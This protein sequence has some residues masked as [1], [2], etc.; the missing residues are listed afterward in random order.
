MMPSF[1]R[2]RRF[3]LVFAASFSTLAGA[4]ENA[5]CYYPGGE[6]ALGFFPCQAFNAPVSSCC[7]AG[8]TCFSNALCIATTDSN[9]FPN[10][11]LGAVQRGAC[12]NPAWNNNICGSACLDDDNKEGQL[13]ACSSQSFCCENDFNAG[14]CNCSNN[15]GAFT[16]SAGVPQTIIQVSDTTFTGTPSISIATNPPKTSTTSRRSTSTSATSTATPTTTPSTSAST[17]HSSSTT[18][19]S[20]GAA[21][22][23]SSPSTSGDDGGDGNGR[24]NLIIGLVVGLVGGVLLLGALGYFLYRKFWGRPQPGVNVVAGDFN[25][26][27]MQLAESDVNGPNFGGHYRAGG[28]A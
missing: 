1:S 3:A 9:S 17:A 13:A 26:T 22:G 14:K 19:T 5:P 20:S 7:P 25:S 2:A 8:W 27:S 6:P 10:L 16:I 28:G 23:T 4:V 24:R 12:T 11:T 21:T 18:S 15:G